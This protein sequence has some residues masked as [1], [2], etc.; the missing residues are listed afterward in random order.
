MGYLLWHYLAES[1]QRFP[2]HAAVTHRSEALTYGSLDSESTCLANL[3]SRHG[4]RNGMRVGMF[5]EKSARAVVAMHGAMKAGAAYVPVD[6]GAPPARAA[7]VLEDCQ[8]IALITT[9]RK[10]AGLLAASPLPSLRLVILT[11]GQPPGGVPG[12][13]TVVEW[14]ALAGEDPNRLQA[15]AA[16]ETDPAY[17]LYTSGSTGNPKGVILTHRHA[18]TFIDWAARVFGIHERDRLAN[19]APLHFDLSV[20]DIYVA[21]K[22]GACVWPVPDEVSPFPMQLAEWID[23]QKISVWYSVPSALI[24]LL[25]HGRIERRQ[26]PSLRQ[27]LFAGEV[28]PVKYLRETQAKMPQAQFWN[29]YG[30]T[31]TN[32]CTYYKVP[33]IAPE[34]TAEIPIGH[35]CENTEVLALT[36]DNRVAGIGE[37]GELL[38]RGPSVM[39]GY[40]GL[41][42]RTAE[43][44]VRNPLQ[45]AYAEPSYRTGD[46]VKLRPDGEYEFIGRKDSQVK[47][48]GYRIELGEVEQTV[49]RHEGIREAAVVAIPDDEIGARLKLVI[50]PHVEGAL[51][52]RDIETFCLAH[53]PRYMV[54][55]IIE[56]RTSLPRTS[57]GKADRVALVAQTLTS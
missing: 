54:P 57:T 8:V 23:V 35:A 9:S 10:V 34:Q 4:I 2:D 3:L 14:S 1:A 48:R 30:P 6:P 24:R 21:L 28:F 7:F 15:T 31:E 13:R 37:V 20:F 43:A 17:V 44:L 36:D 56:F 40:W 39:F 46:Y 51:T 41:P 16:I 32:V 50:V 12:G 47:S 52:Q 27:V 49:Y 42:A 11:D 38:V 33:P 45:G 55:E 22:T 26:F 19:H 29:L 25:L 53:L 18:L 5:F